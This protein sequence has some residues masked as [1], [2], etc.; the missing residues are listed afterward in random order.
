MKSLT[1]FF[2]VTLPA[3][4]FVSSRKPFN[5]LFDVKVHNTT[6]STLNY[7]VGIYVNSQL[8]AWG[9]LSAPP[10]AP[11]TEEQIYYTIR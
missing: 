2:F 11:M 9:T 1:S 6:S 4:T 10:E 3:L 8:K 7:T 5:A